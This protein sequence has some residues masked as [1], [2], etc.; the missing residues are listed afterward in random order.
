MYTNTI[1]YEDIVN[2]YISQPSWDIYNNT[3]TSTVYVE[4]AG[5]DLE[6]NQICIRFMGESGMAFNS[7]E[8]QNFEIISFKFNGEF[9]DVQ[10]ILEIAC[11]SLNYEQ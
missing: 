11:E 9:L 8:N 5:T 2:Y 10:A 3:E 7:I 1:S 4:A 6:G